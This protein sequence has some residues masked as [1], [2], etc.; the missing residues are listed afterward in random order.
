MQVFDDREG[1]RMPLVFDPDG[2]WEYGVTI[3]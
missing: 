1:A 3:D 2:M